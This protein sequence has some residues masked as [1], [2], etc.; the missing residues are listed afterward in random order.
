VTL[1]NREETNRM[2]EES[3]RDLAEKEH[4]QREMR[5]TNFQGERSRKDALKTQLAERNKYA[6]TQTQSNLNCIRTLHS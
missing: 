5:K 1:K 4:M 3:R 6:Y 2:I